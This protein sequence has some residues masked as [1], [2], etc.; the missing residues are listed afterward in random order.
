MNYEI[1]GILKNVEDVD[2]NGFCRN[3]HKFGKPTLR[4]SEILEKLIKSNF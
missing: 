3:S 1:S 4:L 2:R